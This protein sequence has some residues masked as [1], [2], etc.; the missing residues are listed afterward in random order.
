MRELVVFSKQACPFCSLLKL[1][2]ENKGIE[3][4]EIDLSDD[5]ERQAFYAATGTSSMPQVYVTNVGEAFPSDSSVALGGWSDVSN[6]W[7]SLENALG[8]K[9]S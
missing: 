3:F 8:G 2:L 6:A 9:L 5:S 1:E 4:R 7:E